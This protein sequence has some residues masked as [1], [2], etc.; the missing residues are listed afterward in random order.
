MVNLFLLLLACLLAVEIVMSVKFIEHVKIV[1]TLIR[2][3]LHVLLSKV[4]SDIWKEQAVVLYAFR[5]LKEC[6]VI[7][8]TLLLIIAL[9]ILIEFY[10]DTFTNL[11]FSAK[12][13]LLSTVFSFAYYR[14][15]FSK[16]HA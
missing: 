7:L 3:V 2:K 6:L 10:N 15:R 1:A 9:F 8:C 5:L 14:L 4:I 11:L 12:G 13:V 16:L